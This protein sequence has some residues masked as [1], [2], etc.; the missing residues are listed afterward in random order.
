MA[1]IDPVILQLRADVAQYKREVQS[2][3]SLVAASLGRQEA[4]VASLESRFA[5]SSGRIASSLKGI[6]GALAGV[7]LVALARQFLTIADTSKQL[8]AQLRLA[9]ATFGSFG[10]AQ[11]DVARIADET[12]TG[13]T[14][15]ADLYSNFVRNAKELGAS[16]S[17]AARAT[18][19]FSKTL[20]IS[21]ASAAEAGS[22]TLQF[23]QALAAGA[24]RGDELNSILE[25]SP[26]LSRLLSESLGVSVGQ[27]KALGEEGALTSDKLLR[28]LTDQKFTAGI[29]NEFKQLPT[30]F[31]DAMTKV[32][33]SAVTTIGAFDRGGQFSQTLASFVADGA[34]GFSD[35]GDSAEQL[36]IDTRAAFAGLGDAF[37]PLF[38][39][40][41]SVFAGINGEVNN[42]RSAIA[43]LLGAYD[44]LNNLTIDLG[45][46][47]KSFDNRAKGVANEAIR[48]AGGNTFFEPTQLQERSNARG[49]FLK[50]YDATAGRLQGE[51]GERNFQR[52]FGNFDAL[53]N[54][55]GQ[56]GTATVRPPKPSGG[57]KPKTPKAP[58]S[59]LDPEAFAR[60]EA[61]L[62][63]AILAEKARTAGLLQ[64]ETA[65][66]EEQSKF[67]LARIDASRAAS[68]TEIN[69]DDRLTAAQKEKLVALTGTVAAIQQAQVIA[70]KDRDAAE[71]ALRNRLESLQ[72]DQRTLAAQADVADTRQ[73][74]LDI[75]RRL[76]AIMEEEEKARLEAQIAAGQIADAAK[77]RANL[78]TQQA[79]RRTGVE[80]DNES[81]LEAYRRNI[82]DTGKGINDAYETV[83]VNGLEKLNNG[84]TDAIVNS[85]N[86]GSTFKNIAKSIIADL[87]RIAIQ[88]TIVNSLA[89]SLGGGGGIVAGIGKALGFAS[90][91]YTGDGPKNKV[92][93]V[94]HKGEYVV[95]ASA[96]NRL[97]V[98]NLEA[99]ANGRAAS[100]M[101]GVSATSPQR[102][103]VI[104]Q[105][106]Q[107]DARNSVNPDGFARQILA[108]SSQQAQ[109]AAATMGSGVMKAMPQRLQQYQT[110]GT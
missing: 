69:N 4:S 109:Q 2:T 21:G 32:Y 1:E 85:K 19:T 75:E 95:P 84:L 20:K 23:G 100:S 48:R 82:S 71:L 60:Q 92:A 58:K 15:T 25:A 90:G 18:E 62:N 27:L 6:G 11:K 29:D 43:S 94:V 51:A 35:L 76:L 24:L 9:T 91:G 22:A 12:R 89:S 101:S 17:D 44:Q 99:M 106:I 63:D 93:G 105:T 50:G 56:R 10:Q 53:G 104:K 39:G 13:L 38:E 70:E 52:Q 30:T 14:E 41:K 107:V 103:T 108:I 49:R 74:R 54:P 96:V 64:D 86:L 79:S 73:A 34:D 31:D 87:I 72:D 78:E 67:D 65:R 46:S 57:A 59:T 88:Q 77:A 83:A 61:S 55:L 110:D 98:A 42:T 37:D 7:S 97:G 33:N 40:A 66:I 36:G 26:R 47:G 8:D 81:P 28:A 102:T 68:I 3:T 80:R 16:Q 45:N 5:R